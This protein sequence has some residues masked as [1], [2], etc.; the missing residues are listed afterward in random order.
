MIAPKT[1]SCG[2]MPLISCINNQYVVYCPNRACPVQPVIG[3]ARE[4]TVQTWNE[5]RR[6]KSLA[7]TK[8]EDLFAVIGQA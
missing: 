3:S 4:S 6:E 2:S 7:I 8:P 5:M 1:C